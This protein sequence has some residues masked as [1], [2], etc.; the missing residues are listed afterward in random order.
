MYILSIHTLVTFTTFIYPM[1]DYDTY[2]HIQYLFTLQLPSLLRSIQCLSMILIRHIHCQNGFWLG[3]I[4]KR[5]IIFYLHYIYYPYSGRSPSGDGNGLF[6]LGVS[7]VV[8]FKWWYIFTFLSET[9]TSFP[10]A[11]DFN[12]AVLPS[13]FCILYGPLNQS[14]CG[15]SKGYH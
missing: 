7:V 9:L 10:E 5:Y 2:I 14:L 13:M 4:Y 8:K 6:T 3:Y 12:R 1:F 11:R 15:L